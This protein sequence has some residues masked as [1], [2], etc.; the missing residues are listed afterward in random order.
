M[1]RGAVYLLAALSLAPSPGPGEQAALPFALPVLPEWRTETLPFPLEFAPDL[2]YRGLE[3]LRFA[4]GMFTAGSDDFWSYAFVWWIDRDDPFDPGSLSEHLE[5]YFRGLTLAVGETRAVDV[6]GARVG[7]RITA[8][9]EGRFA[10]TAETFDAFTSHEQV[11]L[12]VRGA[13]RDCPAQGFR[14]VLFALSPQPPEHAIWVDLDS[15]LQ[16]FRCSEAGRA[17]SE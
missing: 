8:T 7:A 14:A 2:P 11:L 12:N 6:S 16:G 3:E 4:P 13:I 17:E 15:I 9:E 5:S 1:L 10:G